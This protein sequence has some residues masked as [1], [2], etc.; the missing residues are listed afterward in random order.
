MQCFLFD[1]YALLGYKKDVKEFFRLAK[2][3][4]Y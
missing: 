1:P 2:T 3:G 4:G